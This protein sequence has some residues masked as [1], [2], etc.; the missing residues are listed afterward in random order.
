MG[1]LASIPDEGENALSTLC[2]SIIKLENYGEVLRDILDGPK[3]ED[4]REM[5]LWFNSFDKELE[6]LA[7]QLKDEGENCMELQS[8]LQE[9]KQDY[10]N[11]KFRG[12]L[13]SYFRERRKTEDIPYE[14]ED[15]RFKAGDIAIKL[16]ENL[17]LAVESR[18]K[19]QVS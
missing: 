18:C 1:L 11:S 14:V 15:L 7:R 5:A 4:I 10:L 6:R 13:F 8:S 3:E 12:M 9:V 2:R 16:A 19:R 17:K